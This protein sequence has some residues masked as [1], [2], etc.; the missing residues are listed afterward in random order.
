MTNLRDIKDFKDLVNVPNL[1]EQVIDDFRANGGRVGGLYEGAPI[2]LVHHVGAKTGTKRVSPV[3]YFPQED[4]GMVIVASDQGTG[5]SRLV[6]Q[7]EGKPADRRRG[8]R[9]DIPRGSRG[10]HGRTAGCRLG[11]HPGDGP[12]PGRVPGDDESHHPPAAA[13]P[14]VLTNRRQNRPAPDG[15]GTLCPPGHGACGALVHGCRLRASA[16]AA[17]WPPTVTAFTGFRTGQGAASP[18]E[19]SPSPVGGEYP[20]R[21]SV[22]SCGHPPAWPSRGTG[23]PPWAR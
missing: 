11:G 6:P 2:I 21:S 8:R 14:G 10:D 20:W 19:D 4:G 15:T 3:M 22:P 23:W 18:A 9:R 16:G 7:P 5:E 1:N 13:H 17:C 12:Q